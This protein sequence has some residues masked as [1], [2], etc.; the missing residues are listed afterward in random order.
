MDKMKKLVATTYAGLEQV[1][2]EEL[3]QIGADDVQAA[4]RSVY[5]SGN[6]EMVYRANYSLRTAL[7]ILVPIRNFKIFKV[8]DLYYQAGKI[9]WEE[10]FDSNQTFAVQSKVFSELFQNSMYAS[11]KVKDAIVDRFRRISGQR[12]SVNPNN[13]DIQI[14]LHIANNQ[15]TISLDS[16]G[17]SLHKRGY[18]SGTHDA[19]ISEVLAA[20]MIKL[21]GWSGEEALWDPMC[22]SGTIAIEAAMIAKNV[23][24]G[25]IR[26]S[27]AF[28]KWKNFKSE[29]FERIKNE[30]DHNNVSFSIYGS[31]ISRR[32]ID[33]AYMNA[34]KALVGNIVQLTIA[35]FSLTEKKP[36]VSFLLFNPPYGERILSGDQAFYAMIGERL[37]HHYDGSNAWIISTNACLKSIGLKPASKIPLFNGSLQCSFR[38]YELYKGS[39]KSRL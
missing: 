15:C 32:N 11:L 29:V 13:P 38:K 14:N 35:D 19:P 17:E 23:L 25:E 39:K 36:E 31:D 2:A 3:I 1:L 18:R 16:S 30:K 34:E 7:K 21:S 27:F 12:P 22:G 6:D 26:K 10:I 33:L 24:P 8:D 20:G 28:Q 9:K 4:R 37:K 5:F